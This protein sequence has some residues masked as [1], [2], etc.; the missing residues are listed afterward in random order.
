MPAN[1][2][3]CANPAAQGTAGACGRHNESIRANCR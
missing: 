3:A 2:T 1:K